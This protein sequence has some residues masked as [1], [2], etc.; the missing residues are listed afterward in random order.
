MKP[1]EYDDDFNEPWEFDPMDIF[2]I[3]IVA[4]V[5]IVL[6]WSLCQI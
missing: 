6:L 2:G 5:A 1:N 3:V 4:F